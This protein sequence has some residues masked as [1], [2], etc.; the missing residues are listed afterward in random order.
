M[1]Q[2]SMKTV[3]YNIRLEQEKKSEKRDPLVSI[4]AASHILLARTIQM[5][6]MWFGPTPK[7]P[8]ISDEEME[9]S[10]TIF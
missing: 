7:Q 10:Q 4:H 1:S 8:K 2:G 6:C 3:D 5:H 9:I